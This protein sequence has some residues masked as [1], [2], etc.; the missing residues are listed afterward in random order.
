MQRDHGGGDGGEGEGP[1][2][3]GGVHVAGGGGGDGGNRRRSRR[4][5]TYASSE[6]LRREHQEAA[7]NLQK[8]AAAGESEDGESIQRRERQR[9][10]RRQVIGLDAP[11]LPQYFRRLYV[12]G[13]NFFESPEE[14]VEA[15]R[16]ELG[17]VVDELGEKVER[18]GKSVDTFSGRNDATERELS[19]Y[20]STLKGYKEM[21]STTYARIQQCRDSVDA[22]T[23]DY[24][25][26]TAQDLKRDL[27]T[28]LRRFEREREQFIMKLRKTEARYSRGMEL[29]SVYQGL[30][31]H[32]REQETKANNLLVLQSIEE[33]ADLDRHVEEGRKAL[34]EIQGFA[35]EYSE[36]WKQLDENNYERMVNLAKTARINLNIDLKAPQRA[37]PFTVTLQEKEFQEEEIDQKV[38]SIL[39]GDYFRRKQ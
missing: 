6:Q 39:N 8:L 15:K 7:Q 14:R 27:E 12:A 32:F 19:R 38:D 18:L 35:D 25:R 33:E 20:A 26:E 1:T 16:Q 23:S 37:N 2:E 34:E 17:A 10:E 11:K 4:P 3:L 24:E 13:R 36:L 9:D 21:M 31:S 5:G 22:A 28:D 29:A 30:Y